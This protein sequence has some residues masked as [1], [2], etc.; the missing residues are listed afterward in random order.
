MMDLKT[1]SPDGKTRDPGEHVIPLL[2]L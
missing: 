1:F 2:S